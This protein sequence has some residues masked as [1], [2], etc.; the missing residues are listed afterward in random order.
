MQAKIMSLEAQLN[1]ANQHIKELEGKS[2]AD[3]KTEVKPDSTEAS[4]KFSHDETRS[5]NFVFQRVPIIHRSSYLVTMTSLF[6][7]DI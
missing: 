4:G 7:L 2:T 5:F 1:K 3:S 6:L